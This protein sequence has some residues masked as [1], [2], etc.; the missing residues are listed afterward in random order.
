M[1]RR[2]NTVSGL[3]LAVVSVLVALTQFAPSASAQPGALD[4]E[5]SSGTGIGADQGARVR[6]FAQQ[7]DGKLLFGGYFT[8]YQGITQPHLCRIDPSGDRDA[9]FNSGLNSSVECMALQGDGRIRL[10]QT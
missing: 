5:F 8:R 2:I 4:P 6:C 1:S 10:A 7:P 3:S 9:S